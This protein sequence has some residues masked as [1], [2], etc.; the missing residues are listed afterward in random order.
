MNAMLEPTI[1]A[2]STHGFACSAQAWTRVV[3]LAITPS[4]QGVLVK[5][6]TT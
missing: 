5:P 1:V 6:I 2:A 3:A 4:S